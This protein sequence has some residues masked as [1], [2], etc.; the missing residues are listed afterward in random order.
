MNDGEANGIKGDTSAAGAFRFS[1]RAVEFPEV[2]FN[3]FGGPVSRPKKLNFFVAWKPGFLA[4]SPEI[5]FGRRQSPTAGL[6]RSFKIFS[7]K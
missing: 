1:L 5:R 4:R 7:K 6:A 2:F 3:V